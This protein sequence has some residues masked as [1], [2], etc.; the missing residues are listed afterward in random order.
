[1]LSTQREA[2]ADTDAWTAGGSRPE[3]QALV[4]SYRIV[5]YRI[6]IIDKS[7]EEVEL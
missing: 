4:T 5:L 6:V 7:Q 1:M 2:N 3:M